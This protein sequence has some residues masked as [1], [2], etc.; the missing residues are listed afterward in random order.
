MLPW[1]KDGVPEIIT[2]L[3]LSKTIIGNQKIMKLFELE[4]H[5]RCPSSQLCI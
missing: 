1:N 2:N 4:S 5:S 3:S